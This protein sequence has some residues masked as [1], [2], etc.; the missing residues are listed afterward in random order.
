MTPKQLEGLKLKRKRQANIRHLNSI[1]VKMQH[2][3]RF[4]EQ[5]WNAR[6]PQIDYYDKDQR[7]HSMYLDRIDSKG[8]FHV[9]DLLGE[10]F[11]VDILN[12]KDESLLAL[13]K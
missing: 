5:A 11:K 4:E 8:V 7:L 6:H 9:F 2:A 12:I 3:R 13:I 1:D 10:T